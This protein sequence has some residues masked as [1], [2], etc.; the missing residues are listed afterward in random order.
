MRTEGPHAGTFLDLT[1]GDVYANLAMDDALLRRAEDDG[2]PSC[3]RIWSPPTHAVVL[4]ASGRIASEVDLDA[5]RRDGVTVARR[6]SGGGTVVIG[7][8]ALCFT[9]VLPIDAHPD[10]RSVDTAQSFVLGRAAAALREAGPPVEIR[11]SGDLTLGDLKVSGSAQRRLR[12]WLL[13]HATILH[14]FELPLISRYLLTPARQPAYRRG[15]GHAEF[16]TN[17]PMSAEAIREA[18]VAVW[19]PDAPEPSVPID[20][21]RSIGADLLSD[22]AWIE[23]F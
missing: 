1:L 13:V 10:L 8:G 12:R 19:A 18:L 5:C 16:V 6:T 23:R 4:G 17:L 15:R 2:S 9:V 22:P 7:P 20:L 11:G 3:L 21:A 14:D